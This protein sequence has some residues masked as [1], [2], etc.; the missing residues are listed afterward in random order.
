MKVLDLFAGI[1][2][3]SLGLEATGGFETVAFCEIEDY[4][5]GILIDKWPSAKHYP[6]VTKLTKGI[7]HEDGISHIDVIC[8]GF[9]CQDLSTSGTGRGL[10]GERSGLGFE[11]VRLVD[12]LRPRYIIMEN[13]PELLNGWVGRL[14]GP[15]AELGYD[16]EWECIPAKAVGTPHGRNRV[17]IIAYTSSIGQ[18]KPGGLLNAIR[19]ETDA[20]REASGLVDAFQRGALPFVCDRHDGVPAQLSRKQI[21]ALG[22]AVVPQ[23]PE[24][25]GRAILEAER[26]LER[27]QQ[28]E[29]SRQIRPHAS[30]HR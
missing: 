17:W 2:G 14:F 15:M 16:A 30:P 26:S 19:P 10:D 25:I 12:E 18:Q 5:S 6:D 13:S 8:A 3:M 22:N 9:P 23:I 1:G 24:M 20:Y 11:V 21:T 29:Q 7:L 28:S 27:R 4:Q